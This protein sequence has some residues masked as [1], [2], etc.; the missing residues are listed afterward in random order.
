MTPSDLIEARDEVLRCVVARSGG[1][2][3]AGAGAVVH[4]VGVGAKV[5]EGRTCDAI[6][7]RVYVP[8]KRAQR[9]IDRSDRVPR[10]IDGVPI[11]VVAS[12]PAYVRSGAVPSQQQPHDPLFAGISIGRT[13][14][15]Y[16]TL[17]AFCRST[18]AGEGGRILML[19]NQHVLARD[20]SL[21]GESIFQ[22]GKQDAERQQLPLRPV[23]GLFRWHPIQAGSLGNTVDAGVAELS[24]GFGHQ[25]TIPG[26]AGRIL[27]RAAATTNTIVVKF[28]RTTGLTEGV[29]TDL[30]CTMLVGLD[31]SD[32]SKKATFIDQIRIDRRQGQTLFADA[33]DS[34]S[35][36]LEQ[37]TGNAVGLYFAGPIDGSFGLANHIEAVVERLEIEL[38]T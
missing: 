27:G 19:S 15:L 9:H 5:V 36:V 31:P 32:E 7:V 29:V 17:A 12:P 30:H 38:L 13:D 2:R 1:L 23:A 26:D 21:S 14:T 37:G 3:L 22:P 18:R 6:A 28:G 8:E 10:A 24:G 11:D 16:G 20:N 4:G 25:P 34:G 35:L 33:G